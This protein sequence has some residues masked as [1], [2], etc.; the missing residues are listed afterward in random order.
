MKNDDT[1]KISTE[2]L[3][4]LLA[5]PLLLIFLYTLCFHPV[6]CILIIFAIA[7]IVVVVNNNEETKQERLDKLT[8]TSSTEETGCS[9]AAK[10]VRTVA[11]LGMIG[12]ATGAIKFKHHEG[13]AR[14]DY[15]P[16]TSVKVFD[17]TVFKLPF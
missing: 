14:N 11:T 15:N 12:V 5:I 13:T 17:S 16:S 2:A 3:W 10:L 7:I 8:K 6:A 4:A 1:P 9:D